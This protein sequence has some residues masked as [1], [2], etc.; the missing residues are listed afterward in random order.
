GVEPGVSCISEHVRPMSVEAMVR[1]PLTMFRLLVPLC[2]ASLAAG[3]DRAGTGSEGGAAAASANRAEPRAS[4][5][6]AEAWLSPVEVRVRAV[7]TTRAV[8]SVVI[9]S[10]VSARIVELGFRD[11]EVVERGRVLAKLDDSL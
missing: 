10:E 2:A 9:T 11:E 1:K 4:V 6:V 5:K 8:D 7:G 3:C